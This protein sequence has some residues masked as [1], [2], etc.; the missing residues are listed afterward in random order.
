MVAGPAGIARMAIGRPVAPGHTIGNMLFFG[1]G[2]K[3]HRYRDIPAFRMRKA[4]VPLFLALCLGAPVLAGTV[5]SDQHTWMQVEETVVP[6]RENTT[7][8]AV[9]RGF[10]RKGQVL[11][12]E[13]TAENWIKVRVND[14]LEGW[15]PAT[16]LSRSGPPVDLNPGYVKGVLLTMVGLGLGVFLFL[17][18]SLQIKRRGESRERTRQAQMDAKRRLQNKIQLLFHVEPR[19]HSHLV[20]DQ[21]DLKEFLQSIGYVANLENNQEKF[22]ASCKAFKPNLIVAGFDFHEPV[23][24][25]VETDAMLINTPV[26]YLQSSKAPP[27]SAKGVRAY[28]DTNASEKELSEAIVQCLKKSPEKIRYSVKPVAL[29]GG[30]H[31]GTLMELLHFL[32][33]VKKTGQLLAVSGTAKGEVIL[34]KGDI[35]KASM[36]GLSGAKAAEAILNLASGSFEFHEKDPGPVSA[37]PN[38]ALNTQKILMDWAKNHD[39]SNHHS[40]T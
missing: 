29:K 9:I 34:H 21:V 19:I 17:A 16:S 13:K 38:G 33:A 15:V 26:I 2:W 18:I 30:I 11:A 37:A 39:E 20:M 12:V 35:A 32:A 7:R 22:M 4:L 14:S 5:Q 31:A 1:H 24:K 25:M 40:R 36:R 8:N 6:I 27:T 23:E 10:A 3:T 28:L